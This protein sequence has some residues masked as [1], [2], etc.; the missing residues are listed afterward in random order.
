MSESGAAAA[1]LSVSAFH[2]PRSRIIQDLMAPPDLSTSVILLGAL[3]GMACVFVMLQLERRD[4]VDGIIYETS[5]TRCLYRHL[6][7]PILCGVIYEPILCGVR[8]RASLPARRSWFRLS[9]SPLGQGASS[10]AGFVVG[11]RGWC[12]CCCCSTRRRTRGR[13]G[14][15]E[16]EVAASAVVFEEGRRIGEELLS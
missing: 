13:K 1:D 10:I 12:C 4:H 15:V 3:N 2:F 9:N 5:S 8:R 11:R 7:E 16:V 6:F 14:E